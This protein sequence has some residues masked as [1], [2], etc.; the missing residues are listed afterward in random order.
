MGLFY[1]ERRG[2]KAVASGAMRTVLPFS[3]KSPQNLD[4]IVVGLPQPVL[5]F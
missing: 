2:Y 5:K 4:P 3:L 1:N